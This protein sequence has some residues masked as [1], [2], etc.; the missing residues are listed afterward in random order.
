MS[1][2]PEDTSSYSYTDTSSDGENWWKRSSSHP[3]DRGVKPNK[4]KPRGRSPSRSKAKNGTRAEG[5]APSAQVKAVSQAKAR[6]FVTVRLPTVGF[7]GQM[8]RPLPH[9]ALS[10]VGDLHPS[11]GRGH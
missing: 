10:P 11:R 6:Q 8:G 1:L 7:P 4:K 9:V 5:G 3:K 2:S